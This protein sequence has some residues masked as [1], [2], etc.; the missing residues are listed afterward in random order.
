MIHVGVSPDRIHAGDSV[1]LNISLTNTGAGTCSRV[2]FTVR[3]PAGLV[4]LRG[5]SKIEVDRVLPGESV[6]SK[7]RVRAEK[8]CRVSA[9]QHELF[10]P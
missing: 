3:L 9:D 6:T 8:A 7:L 10:L 5:P 1:E 2:I 4:L